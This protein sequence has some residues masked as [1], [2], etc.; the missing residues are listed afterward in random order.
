MYVC[1]YVTCMPTRM[2]VC[3]VGSQRYCILCRAA[4]G[5]FSI[6]LKILIHSYI[7]TYMNSY[8]ECV[9]RA[10][11]MDALGEL[12]LRLPPITMDIGDCQEKV[13]V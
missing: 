2:Y 10:Y 8:H 9:Y 13:V 7:H 11:R 6:G 4:W 1:M 3:R 12:W 5:Q